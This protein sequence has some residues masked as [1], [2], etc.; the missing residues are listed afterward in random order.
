MVGTVGRSRDS[1]AR[2]YGR[3][4]GVALV[5][6][7][8]FAQI[9][10]HLDRQAAR[11]LLCLAASRRVASCLPPVSPAGAKYSQQAAS[12]VPEAASSDHPIC[13]P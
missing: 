3:G 12:C 4:S 6:I 13:S 7:R 2:S 1:I 5:G 11:V 8:G 10:I 9:P